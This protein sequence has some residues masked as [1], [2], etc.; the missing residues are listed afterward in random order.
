VNV[1]VQPVVA[2]V[3]TSVYVA[4]VLSPASFLPTMF[5]FP[6]TSASL[7][8]GAAIVGVAA[9]AAV[10]VGF[11]FRLGATNEDNGRAEEGEVAHENL[12][13]N[14]SVR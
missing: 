5:H 8:V 2:A 14:R 1:I 6:A 7:S 3:A 10:R 12:P 13:A 11:G 9:A 4:S